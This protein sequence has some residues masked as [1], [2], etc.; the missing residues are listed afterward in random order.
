MF[1]KPRNKFVILDLAN[2]FLFQ[3]ALPVPGLVPGRKIAAGL[4]AVGAV[5]A[6][7]GRDRGFFVV[8]FIDCHNDP[9]G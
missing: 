8:L 1:E 7:R 5:R 9:P 4:V 2:I 3:G 6:F